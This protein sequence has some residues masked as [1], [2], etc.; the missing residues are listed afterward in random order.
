[1]PQTVPH[2]RVVTIHREHAA[3]NFLGIKNENWMAASRDLGAHALRLYLYLA[4]NRDNFQLAL[5]P[6]AIRQEIGM[7]RSTYQDQF[8]VLIDKG[9][10]V[11]TSGNHYAFY[12]KPQPRTAIQA[13]N[14]TADAGFDFR[15]TSDA[16]RS[17][18][19]DV[20]NEP[21]EN[22]EINNKCIPIDNI[23]IN[24]GPIVTKKK[25]SLS[26]TE[27]EMERLSQKFDGF[28]F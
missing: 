3:S 18:P 10:I 15:E 16:T 12:E 28:V 7:A 17:K 22:I 20:K 26:V 5:S 24:N 27:D 25:E 11:E 14:T 23:G 19:V 9:Y 1:M 8:H 6:A 4:A 21:Q 2:Q 13:K